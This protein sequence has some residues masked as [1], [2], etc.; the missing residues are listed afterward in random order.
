MGTSTLVILLLHV[1]EALPTW[2]YSAEKIVATVG[3]S[4]LT[5]RRGGG[6][7]LRRALTDC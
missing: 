1:I 4:L 3:K 6:A 5:V 7:M 2:P